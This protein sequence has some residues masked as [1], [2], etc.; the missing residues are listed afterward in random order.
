M[1]RKKIVNENLNGLEWDR[2]NTLRPQIIGSRMASA[3]VSKHMIE[4]EDVKK[5]AEDAV[6]VLKS[7]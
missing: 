7:T 4:N 2:G 3:L 5:F 1:N 6:F